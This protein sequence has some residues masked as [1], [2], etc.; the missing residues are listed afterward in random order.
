MTNWGAH[1]LDITQWALGMDASGP[2]EVQG[3]AVYNS[4]K[5]YETPQQFDVTFRY[6]DGTIVQCSSGIGK[7]RNGVTFEGEK[8]SIFVTRGTLESS[9]AEILAEPLDGKSTRLY[10]S[11]NH[12]Q[13]WLD[14]IKSRKDP[15]CN[16]EIGHR[17]AT[18]CHLGNIAL[19]TSKKVVW[20]PDRQAIVGAT[21]LA[22]WVGRPYRAPWALPPA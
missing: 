6:A 12:H 9:P 22:K 7:Y 5:L 4:E 19:R 1:H 14:C 17:S 15:I 20:D 8:G 11:E 3:S 13:N 2:V 10:V 18:V 21:E 16:V